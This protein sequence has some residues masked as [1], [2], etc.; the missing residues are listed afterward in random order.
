[1][2]SSPIK[3]YTTISDSRIKL[4][5]NVIFIE[6]LMLKH[7]GIY[8]NLLS[9]LYWPEVFFKCDLASIFSQCQ[10]SIE[11]IVMAKNNDRS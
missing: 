3:W 7:K 1:M 5:K 4:L 11:P 8:T 10:R 2:Y 9:S 6:L